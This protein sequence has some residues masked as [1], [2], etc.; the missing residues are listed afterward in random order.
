MPEQQYPTLLQ[1]LAKV[2]L[3]GAFFLVGAITS[4]L[5]ALGSGGTKCPWSGS[6]VWGCVLNFGLLSAVFVVISRLNTFAA[7]LCSFYATV[8][9]FCAKAIEVIGR[10]GKHT[11]FAFVLLVHYFIILCAFVLQDSSNSPRLCGCHSTENSKNLRLSS[12]D[13]AKKSRRK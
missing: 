1:G 4:L 3:L 11:F 6:R 12:E 13:K 9:R 10:T 8:V 2:D 7:G 5:I